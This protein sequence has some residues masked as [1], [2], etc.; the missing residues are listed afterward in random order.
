[1]SDDIRKD[2]EMSNDNDT[3]RP[4]ATPPVD[5]APATGGDEPGPWGMNRRDVVKALAT[6][7]FVGA[8]GYEA[9]RKS[10]I[11]DDKREAIGDEIQIELESPAFSEEAISQS[12]QTIRIGIIGNGGEGESLV[13]SLGFA[14][15]DWIQGRREAMAKDPRDRWLTEW[16]AQQNLNVEITAVCDVFDVR[17]ERAIAAS[18][19]P[20]RPGD[21]TRTLKPAK[22]YRHYEELLAASDVPL[23][24]T[25]TPRSLSRR[26]RPASTCT[27]RSA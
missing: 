20:L 18:T 23:L 10:S 13:R 24:T 1:M 17:A 5:P 12:S 16:L 22:R 19:Q 27:A 8:L 21:D 7:P 11:Q 26:R 6:V 9:L 25:G 14:H 3:D 4:E 2:D 15:P